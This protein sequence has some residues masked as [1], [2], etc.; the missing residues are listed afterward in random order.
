MPVHNSEIAAIF[1]RLAD[2]LEIEG[3]NPF[4]VRAYRNT[5]RTVQSHTKSMADMLQEG[6]DLSA[7]PDIGDDLAGKI[8]AI[9]DTGKLPLLE[10]VEARTPGALSDLMHIEGL[11]AKRLGQV[12]TWCVMEAPTGHRFCVVRQQHGA[13]EDTAN[14]W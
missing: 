10:E 11:G 8:A 7:L 9:V 3:A 12:R 14:Q 13:F 1:E 4:R 6:Q 2:L 5:A